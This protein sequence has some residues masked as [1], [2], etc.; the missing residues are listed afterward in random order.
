MKTWLRR[1]RGVLGLGAVGGV[2]GW[3]FGALWWFAVSVLGV[4][5]LEFG[6]LGVTGALWA[7]F[8]A[9]ATTGTGLLLLVLG[10]TGSLERLSPWRV[11]AFGALAGFV[12]PPAFVGFW[13][14][15]VALVASISSAFGAVLGGGLVWAAKRAP[16]DQLTDG[17]RDAPGSGDAIDL[18]RVT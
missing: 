2:V 4:G 13:G 16:A 10:S 12:A 15:T 3:L 1:L 18:P 6:S 8:G 11:A 9:F 5:G 14:P 17:D 7:F